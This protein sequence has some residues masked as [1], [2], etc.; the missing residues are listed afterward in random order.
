MRVVATY[1]QRKGRLGFS[2]LEVLISIAILAVAALGTSAAVHYGL[3]SQAHGKVVSE[4][5]AYADR[6]M[7]SMLEQN[8]A[9]SSTSLPA[10]SSGI[11]DPASA[12]V[13]LNAAPFNNASYGLPANSRFTRN[14]SV[15]NCRQASESG[16]QYGWKDDIRQVT[17]KVYWK[18]NSREGSVT[19]QCIS[20]LAR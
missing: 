15:I 10:S 6:L 17:V 3:R 1:Y 5:Q 12:R 7:V 2:I 19:L 20:K 8:L 16:G 4:A 13:A 14:I 18:E 9:F 11:N